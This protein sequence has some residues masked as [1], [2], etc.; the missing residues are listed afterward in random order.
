MAF[1]HNRTVNLLNLHYVVGSIATGGG[2][3][4]FSAYLLRAGLSVP[5]VLLSLAAIFGMRLIIR[6]FLLPLA[7]RTGLRWLVVIGVILKAASYPVLAEVQGVGTGL[8]WLILITAMAD[9]VYWPSYH[10]YFAALGDADHRGQQ[11]GIREAVVASLSIVM[12]LAAGFL[13]VN[14]G[15]RVA[16]VATAV[17]QL[18]SALERSMGP[19]TYPIQSHREAPLLQWP[20]S[21]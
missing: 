21:T 14:F 17:A 3:A 1:F 7:V 11:L 18:F 13:L 12:P 8:Y 16:F 4:F 6:S 2:G 5:S 15:P 10:A 19:R 9:T 20:R